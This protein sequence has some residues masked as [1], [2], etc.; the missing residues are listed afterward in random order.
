SAVSDELA[1]ES[2]D[3]CSDLI[4]DRTHRLDALPGRVVELPIFVALSGEEGAGVAAAH[5]DDDVRG[6]HRFGGKYFRLFCRDV[7]V[8]LGH[9]VN[10]DGVDLVGWHGSGGANLDTLARDIAEESGR[11]LRAAGVVDADEQD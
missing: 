11:H 10:G 2:L 3:A 1:G 6:L 8:E 7:D 9:G 4:A 5:R